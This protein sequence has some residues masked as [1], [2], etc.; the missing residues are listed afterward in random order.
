MVFECTA[1]EYV[2]MTCWSAE[3]IPVYPKNDCPHIKAPNFCHCTLNFQQ[4]L[5]SGK[6]KLYSIFK[7]LRNWNPEINLGFQEKTFAWKVC[8]LKVKN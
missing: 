6:E 4:P 1:D 3:R 7:I 2:Y 5:A 8:Y